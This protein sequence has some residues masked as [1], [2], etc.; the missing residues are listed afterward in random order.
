MGAVDYD[1]MT[2]TGWTVDDVG[3]VL[4]WR[5][6]SH[7]VSN[8]PFGSAVMREVTGEASQWLTGTKSAA[9]LADIF[10]LLNEFRYEHALSKIP[11]DKQKPQK[12]DAYPRPSMSVKEKRE[13]FDYSELRRRLYS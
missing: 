1:L 6:L 7:F 13:P 8:L 10:D 12:P 3:E 5:H 11:K 2:L 4:S 9:L